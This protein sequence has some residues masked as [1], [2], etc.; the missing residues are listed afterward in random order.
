MLKNYLKIAWRNLWKHKLF[1]FINIFGLGLAIPFALLSLMQIQSAYENDNFHPYPKRTYRIVTDVTD[2]AG[3]KII[4]ALSPQSV[5]PVF[6]VL[7]YF[8]SSINNH[9]L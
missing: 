3:N 5:T 6:V 1:S 8:F 4:Y 7:L 2:N 9:C